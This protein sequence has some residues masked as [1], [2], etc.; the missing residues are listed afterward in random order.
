MIAGLQR[1][2]KYLSAFLASFHA[3][4]Q[5]NQ[6]LEDVNQFIIPGLIFAI[7]D[8]NKKLNS[9][10]CSISFIPQINLRFHNSHQSSSGKML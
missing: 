8:M 9:I 1:A 3:N 4:A 10:K 2:Q 7:T 6:P 5:V